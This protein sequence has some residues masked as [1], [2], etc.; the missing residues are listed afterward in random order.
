MMLDELSAVLAAVPA[1]AKSEEYASA[2]IEDNCL[3]KQTIANGGI[4][5]STFANCMGST[6][7][8]LYSGSSRDL[9][10][11]ILRED[12]CWRFL[13]HLRVIRLL[14][15]TASTVAALPD[16]AEFQRASR[17]QK[18]VR[19]VGDRLN[20]S[21]STRSSAIRQAHGRSR[22]TWKA[23]RSRSGD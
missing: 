10:G 6:R 2:I 20:E 11:S 13:Q 4:L 5:S 17:A 15:S 16:S 12:H 23:G 18:S 21:R 9:G 8:S 1:S 3:G 14:L 22:A 19:R 7:I